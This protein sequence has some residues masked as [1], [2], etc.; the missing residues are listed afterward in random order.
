L[1]EKNASKVH[2]CIITD[3]KLFEY[4]QIKNEY[5]RTIS[6]LLA[7]RK[8]F[9]IKLFKDAL[10]T[11]TTVQ[12]DISQDKEYYDKYRVKK[13][14]QANRC[15]DLR[16]DYVPKLTLIFLLSLLVAVIIAV[17]VAFSKYYDYIGW[18]IV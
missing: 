6:K 10:P 4:E 3:P 7:I 11:L 9:S 12:D 14:K 18:Y 17:V 16:R 2:P 5:R 1:I 15:I 13:S 8:G